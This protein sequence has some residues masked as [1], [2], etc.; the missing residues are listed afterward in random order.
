MMFYQIWMDL[1]E[2]MNTSYYTSFIYLSIGAILNTS[3]LL[4]IYLKIADNDNYDQNQLYLILDSLNVSKYM[5]NSSIL[6]SIYIL[7][8]FCFNTFIIILFMILY[9]LKKNNVQTNIAFTVYGQI[10]GYLIQ[11]YF[12]SIN[13]FLLQIQNTYWEQIQNLAF[14]LL[15]F[16]AIVQQLLF[17]ITL[18]LF[19]HYDHSQKKNFLKI[20]SPKTLIIQIIT[21]F[22][23]SFLELFINSSDQLNIAFPIVLVILYLLLFTQIHLDLPVFQ[24]KQINN[25]FQI[26]ICIQFA[27]AL[28]LLV[29]YFINFFEDRYCLQVI[30]TFT[31]LIQLNS[32]IRQFLIFRSINNYSVTRII[33]QRTIEYLKQHSEY[34]LL[35]RGIVQMH[36]SLCSNINCFYRSKFIYKISSKGNKKILINRDSIYDNISRI[37]NF[38]LK[39]SYETMQQ[40]NQDQSISIQLIEL[41]CYK[42]KLYS[43]SL[44]Q[45]DKLNEDKLNLFQQINIM[46]IKLII[47]RLIKQK[48]EQAY[49][50]KLPFDHLLQCESYI[51]ETVQII[52][53]IFGYQLQFWNYLLNEEI[54]LIDELF[55]LQKI[56]RLIKKFQGLQKQVLNLHY[57][58]K[59]P[60]RNRQ[61][62]NYFFF[63]LFI[64]NKKLKLQDL[65]ILPDF[66]LNLDQILKDEYID[67]K[68][69]D[70]EPINYYQ[71][72]F[73]ISGNTF[74]IQINQSCIV[75]NCTNNTFQILN[76]NKQS[77][78]NSSA[79]ILMPQMFKQYHQQFINHFQQ[80]GQ[81]YN[82]YKR[83]KAFCI[84]DQGY[85]ITVYKYLKY[86]YNYTSN[87][88][89]Y[90]AMFRQI[91]TKQQYLLL[92]EDWEIDSC[93]QFLQDIIG[94][95]SLSLFILAPKTIVF[96]EYEKFLTKE[97]KEFFS[98]NAP[99]LDQ[100][101]SQLFYTQPS[102][103]RGSFSSSNGQNSIL[104]KQDEI[105]R[106]YQNFL[107]FDDVINIKDKQKSKIKQVL[108]NLRVP[109]QKYELVQ[110]FQSKLSELYKQAIYTELFKRQ[111]IVKNQ[112]GKYQIVKS[113]FI[114]RCKIYQEI[115]KKEKFK[116]IKE[117]FLKY[118]QS[119]ESIDKILRIEGTLKLEKTL[120]SIK[121]ILIKIVRT[122]LIKENQKSYLSN[123]G[124]TLSF[125]TP[126]CQLI[127][128]QQTKRST[129]TQL[130]P[131]H[132][133]VQ[134]YDQFD[135]Y[136]NR[137]SMGKVLLPE[138]QVNQDFGQNDQ[139][140]NINFI[141]CNSDLLKEDT[142][143]I[144][145]YNP[146]IVQYEFISRLIFILQILI[147]FL[148]F[149]F[150]SY[151]QNQNTI[152]QS[153]NLVDYLYEYQII[154]A[155]SY[156]TQIDIELF[157]RN[158]TYQDLTKGDF[159]GFESD[160][161]FYEYQ[162]KVT[163]KCGDY[164]YFVFLEPKFLK[165][166][167]EN[168]YSN[169][170]ESGLD[171]QTVYQVNVYI[172]NMLSSQKFKEDFGIS[173]TFR[174]YMLPQFQQIQAHSMDY[175]F[176]QGLGFQE[177]SNSNFIL[178]L[179]LQ[180]ILQISNL[181][182]LIRF[183]FQIQKQYNVLFRVQAMIPYR[184]KVAI[185]EK[186]STSINQFYYVTNNEYGDLEQFSPRNKSHHSRQ[187]T[188]RRKS[189]SRYGNEKSILDIEKKH[190][191]KSDNKSIIKFQQ[192]SQQYSLKKIVI[193]IILN[194]L[195]I[196]L[197]SI[198][199][200]ITIYYTLKNIELFNKNQF[201]FNTQNAWVLP[202]IKEIFTSQ[203]QVDYNF[204]DTN[205]QIILQFYFEQISSEYPVFYES[206]IDEI[207]YLFD[208]NICNRDNDIQLEQCELLI[209][210]ALTRGIREYDFLL[211]KLVQKVLNPN[212]ERYEN[213]T[214]STIYEFNKLYY[215]VFDH[216][217]FAKEI[218][219]KI[220]IETLEKHDQVS[221][222]LLITDIIGICLYFIIFNEFGYVLNIK[223]EYKFIKMF[224][225]SFMPN[226]SIN[227]QKRLRVE[228][229]KARF[230]KK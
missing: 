22:F 49:K 151:I 95:K 198:A 156:N 59:V 103:I 124:V 125:Q 82:L 180:T 35:L 209:N 202:A 145:K 13:G 17:L 16:I 80:T 158:Y 130:S 44:T 183:Q 192:L 225:K 41:L 137:E 14:I 129:N 37:S 101:L 102:M 153:V 107:N 78:V 212:D 176:N 8:I 157:N 50:S 69:S 4:E 34:L 113:E 91:Q 224:Y 230:I 2:S 152:V 169:S 112:F 205:A 196:T 162:Q 164:M 144:E 38:F 194:L 134:T 131:R 99:N 142:N 120:H 86:I 143:K 1:K 172:L 135:L 96:S 147:V 128:S 32:K 106:S 23:N 197:I 100:N 211:S 190:L 77:L 141:T 119:E 36:Q 42:L 154:V 72:K 175:L 223:R 83:K 219:V 203:K 121:Y 165:M 114:R 81:S 146:Q 208:N 26:I 201:M 62:F 166:L 133:Y 200:V 111:L 216:Y 67:E 229:I 53:N 19:L 64:L 195:L 66:Q 118:T 122:E 11:P 140:K 188:L 88:I 207:L 24:N 226:V 31:L 206:N 74:I 185:I 213:I 210:G 170:N 178:F 84:H 150:T 228:L 9:Y 71:Q 181:L 29:S 182:Y 20:N 39:C 3:P 116:I 139:Y 65:E 48:N 63:K 98:L 60:I 126:L 138:V 115:I 89:E 218:W 168:F 43:V 127:S 90:I 220:S 56:S 222:I 148:S 10:I 92:N 21:I 186:I 5:L 173:E 97:N 58:Q 110:E 132:Q 191:E 40:K 179:I 7:I 27:L 149:F 163:Q 54:R 136:S 28:N 187:T 87:Q 76:Y 94:I 61:W 155:E 70:E 47:S 75:K 167:Y 160:E 104:Q 199:G 52:I 108:F 55:I 214:Y 51:K 57:K 227:Q 18:I 184:E 171:I 217:T 215:F 46:N 123:C 85:I 68:S 12:W 189:S 221:L 30:L 45:I 161:Q 25:Y 33:D 177:I 15:D 73:L 174:Q 93:T 204:N 109:K 193:K 79:V 105:K 159:I 6:H 117:L